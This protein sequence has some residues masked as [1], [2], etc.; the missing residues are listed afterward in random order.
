MLLL[1]MLVMILYKRM[2]I[3]ATENFN[4]IFKTMKCKVSINKT[5]Q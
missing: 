5:K 1:L 3:H 2:P 4:T